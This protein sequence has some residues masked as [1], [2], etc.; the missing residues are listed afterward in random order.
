[1]VAIGAKPAAS[2]TFRIMPDR[3]VTGY[4]TDWWD[5]AALVAAL[6]TDGMAVYE[7]DS[8]VSG[9][10]FVPSRHLVVAPSITRARHIERCFREINDA[11][12]SAATQDRF[13]VRLGALLG[14]PRSGTDALLGRRI[15]AIR[16]Q[17]EARLDPEEIRFAGL[18][19]AG[20][21]NGLED[22][23]RYTRS[24]AAAFIAAFGSALRDEYAAS[25]VA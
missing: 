4:G 22:A 11:T 13:H 19:F 24:A 17:L 3:L 12:R 10:G 8:F 1:M 23:V 21:P 9:K 25:S 14:F 7:F 15:P 5:P 2:R 6:R 18:T 16:A 20:D